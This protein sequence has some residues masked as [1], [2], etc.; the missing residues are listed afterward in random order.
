M[1]VARIALVDDHALMRGALARVL[2]DDPQEPRLDVVQVSSLAKLRPKLSAGLELDLVIV[3]AD[4]PELGGPA[5]L[6][7]F[8]SSHPAVPLMLMVDTCDAAVIAHC[9]LNGIAG[10]LPK[11]GSPKLIRSAVR[12]VLAGD[13]WLHQTDDSP[14]LRPTPA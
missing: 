8:R 7:E 5:G 6:P 11:S 2:T 4:L 9:A 12:A 3:Q 10:A 1:T 13:G 14:R